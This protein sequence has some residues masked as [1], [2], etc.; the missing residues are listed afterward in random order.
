VQ[1]I[2][3]SSYVHLSTITKLVIVR[4]DRASLVWC[5]QLLLVEKK[6]PNRDC[7]RLVI[8]LQIRRSKIS[9]IEQEKHEIIS[10]F[11]NTRSHVTGILFQWRTWR[12]NHG[13][14]S[15]T[16]RDK[17]KLIYA[18]LVFFGSSKRQKHI[19]FYFSVQLS[20][21]YTQEIKNLYLVTRKRAYNN[22]D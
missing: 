21:I 18:N 22:L 12:Q 4:C 3:V 11:V 9:M 10:C 15:S 5:L 6:W 16:K 14:F 2:I 8:Y 7:R 20:R 17:G 13:A 19:M 1:N